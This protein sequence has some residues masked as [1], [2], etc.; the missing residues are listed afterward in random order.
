MNPGFRATASVVLLLAAASACA[1]RPT[2]T[3]PPATPPGF[4]E[5]S[6]AAAAWPDPGW[7]RGFASAELDRLV[8][9]GL[10]ANTDLAAATARLAQGDAQV[11]IAGARL[12]P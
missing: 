10:A 11:R 12:L 2:A 5:G 7:W 8:A 4:A 3:E 9:D 1:F 6:G